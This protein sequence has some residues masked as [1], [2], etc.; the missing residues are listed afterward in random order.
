SCWCR[1]GIYARWP[2]RSRTCTTTPTCARGSA[3]KRNA[4]RRRTH[5]R[6]ARH[7]SCKLSAKHSS[8]RVAILSTPPA[9]SHGWGRYNRDLI[10]ALV[11]LDIEIVFITSR[12]APPAAD[13]KLASYHH[14][15]P[16]LITPTRMT[17]LRTLAASPAVGRLTAACDA[18][19]VIAE[20]YA[21]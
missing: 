19:H 2:E 7:E 16:S 4:S 14:I 15:L 21:L 10:S 8:M 1:L 11:A 6:R 12:D 3:R 17:V 18:V 9:T 20:P 5:G 13:L